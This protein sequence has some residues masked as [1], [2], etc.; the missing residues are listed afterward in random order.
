MARARRRWRSTGFDSYSMIVTRACFCPSSTLGPMEVIV[1]NGQVQ[2]VRP[3]DGRGEIADW[4]DP[5]SL[6]IPAMFDLIESAF[7]ADQLQVD[8]DKATG[9][10]SRIDIDY[11]YLAVDDEL[12]ITIGDFRPLRGR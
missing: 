10:P 4:F 6:T 3:I 2:S 11:I 7:E 12:R 9:V 8:F 1:R 5:D